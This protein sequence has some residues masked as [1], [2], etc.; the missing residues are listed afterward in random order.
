MLHD[1]GAAAI[2]RTSA[3]ELL[4]RESCVSHCQLELKL[5]CTVLILRFLTACK[6]VGQSINDRAFPN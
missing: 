3:A 4:Q 5:S 2:S 6:S 1:H